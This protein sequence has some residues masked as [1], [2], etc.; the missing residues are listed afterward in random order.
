[1]L[2]AL[3]GVTLILYLLGGL[4]FAARLRALGLPIDAGV[5]L[6]STSDLLVAGIRALALGL[7]LAAAI[8]PAV[9]AIDPRTVRPSQT[10]RMRLASALVGVAITTAV[11]FPVLREPMPRGVLVG[12]TALALLA[13]VAAVVA[14]RRAASYRSFAYLL[15]TIVLALGILLH[16]VSERLPPTA[17]DFVSIRLK[18]GEVTDGYYISGDAAAVHVAVNVGTR[19][20]GLIT[21][22]PR[23][24]IAVVRLIREETPVRPIG[25]EI[26][27]ALVGRFASLPTL[28]GERLRR[29]DELLEYGATVRGG[30]GWTVPPILPIASLTFLLDHYE[31]F[32]LSQPHPFPVAVE[33]VP[34]A[35][36]L[37]SPWLY[38]GRSFV[39]RGVLVD[40]TLE[41]WGARTVQRLIVLRPEPTSLIQ[42]SCAVTR[43]TPF[44]LPVGAT[45]DVH[46]AVV[47]WGS[48]H[49]RAE[50]VRETVLACAAART[51][52][53]SPDEHIR[54]QN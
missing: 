12:L 44:G 42:G 47:A 45:V 43:R 53:K 54:D 49:T 41:R 33:R 10:W 25:T 14:L 11:A 35:S 34:L 2:G 21:S 22:V 27:P 26:P 7:V 17:M 40:S 18:S 39:V 50:S 29:R 1:M 5:T 30:L 38:V 36:V 32:A 28:T 13:G 52:G 16:G 15:A 4:I 37:R 48:F 9:R 20:I 51:A 6:L 19:T 23:S 3:A 31:R 46:A 8:V 24:D